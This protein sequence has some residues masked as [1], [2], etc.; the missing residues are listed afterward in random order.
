MENV[1]ISIY[2]N[3]MG[4]HLDSL[5]FN[6][7]MTKL[8]AMLNEVARKKSER[9]TLSLRTA[10]AIRYTDGQGPLNQEGLRAHSSHDD[11][12]DLTLNVCLSTAPGKGLNISPSLV[13]CFFHHSLTSNR[14]S[15]E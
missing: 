6:D 8:V 9:V 4:F 15:L 11:R 12:T 1:F 5:G 3:W 2:Q 7:F 13:S 14:R 10:F